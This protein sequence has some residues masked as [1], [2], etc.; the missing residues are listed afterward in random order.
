M[1]CNGGHYGDLNYLLACNIFIPQLTEG[2][3]KPGSKALE[4]GRDYIKYHVFSFSFVV[5]VV[6]IP[7]EDA[8]FILFTAVSTLSVLS[9]QSPFSRWRSADL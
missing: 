3:C 7:N 5:V 4:E 1:Y 2:S 6:Y 9:S 8:F